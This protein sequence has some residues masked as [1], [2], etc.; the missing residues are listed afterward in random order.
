M[1]FSDWW[2]DRGVDKKLSEL[3]DI[4][5]DQVLQ[6]I[7]AETPAKDGELCSRSSLLAI[8]NAIE[9]LLN[10]PPHN[11]DIKITKRE[12]SRLSNKMLNSEIM[13]QKK[14]GKENIKLKAVIHPGDVR[15][16]PFFRRNS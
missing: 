10:N 3:S 2:Y 6:R 4:E 13:L 7:P 8:R 14:D 9:W 11:R 1:H 12:A 5:L 15:K 16:L